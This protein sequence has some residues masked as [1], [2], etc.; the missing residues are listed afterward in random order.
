[1]LQIRELPQVQIPEV[2]L[3]YDEA[4]G[5]LNI[6][7]AAYLGF[8]KA[9]LKMGAA[10]ELCSMGCEFDPALS[11]HYNSLAARQGEPEAE[12]AIS[13]W[14]LCGYE[15]IFNKNE[16]LAYV[17]AER[18]AQSNL[19]TAEFAM[20]YFN[21]IG[22]H[23]P[24]NVEKAKEWYEKAAKN[25]NADALQRIEGLSQEQTLSK[26]DHEQVAINRIRSQYGSKRGARPDRFKTK[27]PDM[28]TITDSD[29]WANNR[30]PIRSASTAPYP[31][32]GDPPGI[33]RPGSAA[34]YPLSDRPPQAGPAGG[35]F[36]PNGGRHSA[37]SG[38]AFR[39]NPQHNQPPRPATTTND[40]RRPQ[41]GGPPRD[42]WGRPQQRPPQGPG[43][44]DQRPGGFGRGGPDPRANSVSPRPGGPG[45][46][47]GQGGPQ[48]PVHDIGYVAPL[49]PRKQDRPPQGQ[50]F[51]QGPG[52]FP[53]RPGQQ[54]DYGRPNP[55]GNRPPGGG[56]P[57]RQGNNNAPQP[58]RNPS[59]R[60]GGPGGPGGQGGQ[61]Q[62]PPPQRQHQQ[63]AQKPAK[64]QAPVEPKGP[65]TFAEM[66]IPSQ[67]KEGDCVSFPIGYTIHV[68]L[69]TMTTGCH[70]ILYE[71][72]RSCFKSVKP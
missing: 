35:F 51:G 39:L 4:T 59:G 3:P 31:M 18:A 26:Q 9:Q 8:A 65:K 16:E 41:Q 66:G 47:P 15:G 71:K 52:Q 12:M 57:P 25:G 23:V 61:N 37:E 56:M 21:E 53:Q 2:L 22:M 32:S 10:Y 44:F 68:H 6:E 72:P 7:K 38:A 36:A 70:V 60:P 67:Q 69:L 14:F 30:A 42:E 29:E 40:S 43:G 49:A 1:M 27:V 24:V 54:Q 63:P 62:R 45:G 58:Q 17:Y 33:D 19:A 46:R 48:S 55:Q 13:K 20:G 50:G 5:R 64:A 11:L 28:P 34:P